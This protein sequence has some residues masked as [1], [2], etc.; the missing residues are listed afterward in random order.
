MSYFTIKKSFFL[1]SSSICVEEFQKIDKFFNI[2]EKSGVGDIIY[3]TYKNDIKTEIGNK[4][5]NPFNMFAA[6][7]Y[8]FAFFNGSLRTI[9]DLCKFDIRFMY[10][11]E[12]QT[13][14]YSTFCRFINN[15][16]LPNQ[17]KIFSLITKAIINEFNVDISVQ[18]IDGTKIEA[19]ANKYKFV[20]KPTKFH[21]KLNV[22]IKDLLELMGVKYNEDEFILSEQLEDILIIYAQNNNIDKNNLPT[23]KGIKTSKEVKN[24][25]L[26]IKYLNKLT[27]YEIK[28]KICGPNRNSYYKTDYDATAMALKT[29]YYSGHGSNMHA[30][31]N[32][33]VSVS[34]GLITIYGVYQDRTDYHT[35]IP[36]YDKYYELYNEYPKNIVGDS[37]YG[38]YINYKY[39]RKHQIG[40]YLKFQ[41]WDGESSGKRPQLFYT[42]TDGVLCLNAN[43]GEEIKFTSTHQ[44]N[45]GGKLFKFSGCNNCSY[46]YKCKEKLKNKNEDYR[47]VELIP[48]YE[49]LKEQARNNLLDL[50]GIMIRVNRSIQ[51]EGAFGQVKNNMRFNRFRRRGMN[52]VSCEIMLMC[53]G[54]NIRKLWS[55]F[56]GKELKFNYWD[57]PA[58]LKKEK[59][60]FPKPKKKKD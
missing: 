7:I 14:D 40:N 38:I 39:L 19:N 26:G 49:L 37:G 18:Y 4:G 2:L 33:Q 5:Y 31:Y 22:K 29:D 57:I 16:I 3:E 47:Q 6:V 46:S 44:R 50:E 21:Q 27:E 41:Q 32:V 58:D 15:Y 55:I 51:V 53:L 23:G 59:F 48:D 17:Y 1:V 35:L 36:L 60:P 45:K 10:I 28:E 11:M 9:D 30:A 43:I 54:A 56:D 34:S 8:C 20:W 12:Q 24:Y 52:K 42:F 13:P 25:K